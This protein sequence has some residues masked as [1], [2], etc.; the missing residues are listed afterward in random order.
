MAAAVAAAAQHRSVTFFAR[1]VVGVSLRP[2]A[3]PCFTVLP[4][5]AD[6]GAAVFPPLR[7]YDGR[8]S[9][10][11]REDAKSPGWWLHHCPPFGQRAGARLPA[12]TSVII[13]AAGDRFSKRRIAGRCPWPWPRLGPGGEGKDFAAWRGWRRLFTG[14]QRCCWWTRPGC[15]SHVVDKADHA[16]RHQSSVMSF[17]AGRWRDAVGCSSWFD[18]GRP[19]QSGLR[20]LFGSCHH[21]H[22]FAAVVES[23]GWR[24]GLLRPRCAHQTATV[25]GGPR[26]GGTDRTPCVS[27]VCFC[28]KKPADATEAR[29]TITLASTC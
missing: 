7:L 29:A 1:V 28:Q 25:V 2:L 8:C 22:W 10:R 5:W 15:G 27:H 3:P 14:C 11:R 13:G 19:H 9:A 12:G 4:S 23:G 6:L 21:N 26:L 24:A 17:V 18:G 16:R 20:C